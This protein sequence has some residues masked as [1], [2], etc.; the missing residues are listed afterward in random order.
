MTCFESGVINSI[1]FYDLCNL[2]HIQLDCINDTFQALIAFIV[3]ISFEFLFLVGI[4]VAV[5]AGNVAE[6]WRCLQC[7]SGHRAGLP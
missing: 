1:R 4:H 2:V 6:L 3:P 7:L 5:L